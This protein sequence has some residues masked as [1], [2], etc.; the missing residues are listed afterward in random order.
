MARQPSS[1]RPAAAGTH[2]VLA[3]GRFNPIKNSFVAGELS[4]RLEG[5]DDLGQ[6]FQGMR[7][8]E[9][10]IVLP[11]GGFMRRPGFRHVAEVKTSAKKVVL[12]PFEFSTL[13]AYMVEWGDLYARFYTQEARLEDPPA[14]PVEVVSPFPEV[15]LFDIAGAQSADVEFVG[16]PNKHPYKLSR[17]SAV[18]FALTRIAWKDGHA[19]LRAVNLD[20]AFTI[21]V[22]GAGPYTLTASAALWDGAE[23]VGRAVRVA[24]IPG[25]GW[26]EIT[27][28]G[29]TT[30]AT[31]DLK[32]GAAPSGAKSDWARGLFSDTEGPTAISFHEGRLWYGGARLD[33]DR[34]VG[35]VSDDFENFLTQDD[36]LSDAINAD[37]SISRRVVSKTVNGIK[38][39]A[40]GTDVLIIGTSGGEF[41]LRGENDDI[42]TPQSAQ[43]RPATAR[44]GR[45]V[46]PVLLDNQTIFL[47][48][49]GRTLR[50]FSFSIESDGF[51]ARPVS[52][53]AEHILDSGAT[54][55][56][57]Q[58]SPD[59]V[60]WLT[61]ADGQ[62]I[63][64][65]FEREQDVI[66]AH[67]HI[68]GGAFLGGIAQIE[69]V[70]AIS[71]PAGT[72]TQVWVS[73]R[74]TI[75]GTEKRYVEFMED[76]FRPV[77]TA[78]STTIDKIA[79]TEDA[80]FVDSGL[81]LDLPVA[82]TGISSADPAVATA[83][84]HGFADGNTVKI[85]GVVG[86]RDPDDGN[87]INQL[88][89]F[90][91]ANKTNDTF[92]L[93][94]LDAS[95]ATDYVTGGTAR[96]EVTTVSG[97]GHLEG[98]TLQ[99]LADGATLPDVVVSGGSVTLAE[100]ASI[101]HIGLGYPTIG[102]T[103]RFVGGGR[104]GTDQG[105]LA[106]I[107]RAVLRLL[108]SLGGRVGVGADPAL[109]EDLLFRVG[110]DP[111][112]AGPPLF[113]GDIAASLES[114]WTT[115]G[116]VYFIQDLPLPFTVLSI[117]PRMESGED[118]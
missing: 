89:S 51:V 118:A 30:V 24:A 56:T 81:S 75:N 78:K 9:N 37:K 44:G 107:P 55:M 97:L 80:F 64:F 113:T 92:E 29:S 96:K 82:I 115:E 76:Q 22:T 7:Q 2:R 38:W 32:G 108:N 3:V 45:A 8:A 90:T 110:D 61:R 17:T 69:S 46:N 41:R 74:R 33:P 83:T 36:A 104:V 5:R 87:I 116:T 39:L 16:T 28:V 117:M 11:H 23:D 52:I 106:H 77:I 63:G 102:E 91:V 68:A 85:R 50:E 109:L 47:Q 48:K 73:V 60:I 70:A 15:D 4:P 79:A 66:G 14:T 49:D 1:H 99:V 98:E 114:E 20:S 86:L 42:L 10:G 58:Q 111:M 88:F 93:E 6:Y 95:A 12:R 13:Q 112:D 54:Q 34:I 18:A 100:K 103:Q 40:S 84:A 53:L 72:E 105:Q 19:P 21:T 71:N 35:S 27:S 62:L 57:Y 59:S 65:T 94:G 67:R 31:A 26:F 43:I 25:E 101:I